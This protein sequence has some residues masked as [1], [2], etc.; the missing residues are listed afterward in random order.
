[1]KRHRIAAS[2]I[3][4]AVVAASAL[5]LSTS[6]IAATPGVTYVT[7]SDIVQTNTAGDAGWTKFTN[8]TFTSSISGLA[9]P[10]NNMLS[11]GVATPILASTGSALTSFAQGTTFNSSMN[12]EL[13]V[14]ITMFDA[15]GSETLLFSDVGTDP[16]SDPTF[17]WVSSQPIGTLDSDQTLYTLAQIDDELSTNSAL[18]GWTIRSFS[19]EFG[20]NVTLYTMSVNGEHFSFLPEPVV[21]AAPTTIAQ[22]ALAAN[23]A[24]VTTTGFLPNEPVAFT[25]DGGTGT[26]A[27][28]AD[29]TGKLTFVYRGT[30]PAGS[31]T[32]VLRGTTSAV[33]QSF[34]FTVTVP[35]VVVPPTPV[36]PTTPVLAATGADTDVLA[37]LAIGALLL[38][39]GSALAAAAL[40][41]RRAA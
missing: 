27:G 37:S 17:G 40:K 11:Y 15:G 10:M 36:D 2:A 19:L 39:S 28:S 41:R 1:M 34:A 35:A 33:V 5:G 21:T 8:S 32:L 12:S 22:K 13:N 31:H 4:V 26:T 6:A 29:S 23:G 9:M 25:I 20:S 38:L 24:T 3:G 30:L 18:A 7:A 16:L 14:S